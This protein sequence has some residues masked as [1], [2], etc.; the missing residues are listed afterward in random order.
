MFS[1]KKFYLDFIF[2]II[3]SMLPIIFLQLITYPFMAKYLSVES[4]GIALILISAINIITQISGIG[5]NNARIIKQEEYKKIAVNGDFRILSIILII[6]NIM[7]CLISFYLIDS[8]ISLIN[9]LL[10]II[11]VEFGF[12]KTY[13]TAEYSVNK[14]FKKILISNLYLLGGYILGSIIFLFTKNWVFIFLLGNGISLMYIFKTTKIWKEKGGVSPYFKETSLSIFTIS[15]SSLLINLVTY[16][17]RLILFPLLGASQ[18]AIYYTASIF[19]KILAMGL[20]PI[21][22]VLLSYFSKDFVMN[23]KKFWKMNSINFI[24]CFLFFIVAYFI[25][26]PIIKILYPDLYLKVSGLIHIAN[27]TAIV[28]AATI[29][30]QPTILRFCKLK[31]QIYIQIIHL[32]M[33]VVLSILFVPKYGILGFAYISLGIALIKLVLLLIIGTMSFKNDFKDFVS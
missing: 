10:L 6:L 31:W 29:L 17:D 12:L 21:S 32:I 30:I 22:S 13:F 3:A 4:Y 16:A 15:F 24:L 20:S 27:L 23:N 5:I 8:N 33:Y 7:I 2:N 25:S 26:E 1:K 18:V 14:D 11:L 28:Y 19:G 9:I